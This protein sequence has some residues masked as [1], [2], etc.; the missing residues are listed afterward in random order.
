MASTSSCHCDPRC[1]RS[2]NTRGVNVKV[3]AD[4][5]LN[6]RN[7]SMEEMGSGRFLNEQKK[8]S[9]KGAPSFHASL[10]DL[11][12]SRS[13]R[14]RG[15]ETAGCKTYSPKLTL[16]FCLAQF[17]HSLLNRCLERKERSHFRH[18]LIPRDLWVS[19]ANI[20]SP[21]VF[22][23]ISYRLVERPPSSIALWSQWG[24]ASV[25]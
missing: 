2:L 21:L 11:D 14:D 20:G 19:L 25:E 5:G 3:L 10:T 17:S 4:H 15:E 9:G 16:A 23:H 7:V 1:L 22:S 6:N 18:R 24:F 12:Y 13:S 8:R